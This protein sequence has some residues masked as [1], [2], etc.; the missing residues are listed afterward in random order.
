MSKILYDPTWE[1]ATSPGRADDFFTYGPS[2]SD[3]ALC[4]EMSRLAYAKDKGQ[5][6]D[7]LELADFT[8]VDAIG[9]G[10]G[11][12]GTQ[13]F[14][15]RSSGATEPV[16]VVAFR[17]TDDPKDWITDLEFN[18]VPVPW[19]RAAK[20]A[21]GF[22]E[23][24]P[25][26]DTLARIVPDDTRVLYTGH[27][28]GAA[29]ATLAVARHPHGDLYTFGSPHVGD[30]Q[31]KDSMYGVKHARYV[32]CCD[33]VAITVP[34]GMG[35]VHVGDL[36]YIDRNGTVLTSPL[37]KAIQKDQCKARITYYPFKYIMYQFKYAWP[38]RRVTLRGLA[39]HAPINYLS[40]VT[41][42]R[43]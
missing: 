1:S 33:L 23:A 31:F 43:A 28:L 10:K 42:L 11:E 6:K 15:A 16:V 37:E 30:A 22:L 32:D 20:V 38:W 9:Y 36:H 29:L 40:A 8:L 26:M 2:L 24:L 21:K 7:Y 18:Q 4:A 35:Y 41:G 34:V 25:C 3:A 17:G 12:Q 13:L 19:C 39:D 27:S 14:V 5:L